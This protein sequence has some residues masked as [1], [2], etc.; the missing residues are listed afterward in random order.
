M[1]I[2][3]FISIILMPLAM[4]NCGTNGFHMGFMAENN[5]CGGGMD[6]THISF[7]RS[8]IFINFIVSFVTIFFILFKQSV[9]SIINNIKDN[10]KITL[11]QFNISYLMK[12]FDRLLL[13]YSSGII[14][15]KTFC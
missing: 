5:F 11:K 6:L 7:M 4:P 12:P 9:F 13:A 14:E 3:Y 1:A 2:L 10:F 8:L 15:N